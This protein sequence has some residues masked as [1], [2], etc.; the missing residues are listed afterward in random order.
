MTYALNF[1]DK[2]SLVKSDTVLKVICKVTS[3]KWAYLKLLLKCL[4]KIRPEEKKIK[5][6][7][8]WK[9]AKTDTKPKNAN[10]KVQNIN[11]K[12]LFNPKNTC[13]KPGFKTVLLGKNVKKNYKQKAAQNVHI[14]FGHFIFTK[15]I[16]IFQK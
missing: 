5:G 3:F 13:N 6:S 14:S 1:E 15:N 2:I 7:I 11:I 8:F 12:P 10:L 16:I 4:H 9:V